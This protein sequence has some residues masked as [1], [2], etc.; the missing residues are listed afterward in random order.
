MLHAYQEPHPT[1][2]P[3]FRWLQNP[4]AIRPVWLEQPERMAAVALLT[5]VGFL[6]YPVL[7]RQVRLDLLTHA[8]QLPGNQG[9]TMT[10][11]AAVV[12]TMFSPVALGQ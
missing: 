11:T 12:C 1:G 5:V 7:Q 6:V 9:E 2:D 3:G 8:H 4:A 10:P